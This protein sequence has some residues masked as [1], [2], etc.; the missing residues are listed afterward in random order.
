MN[1]P[2]IELRRLLLIELLSLRCYVLLPYLEIR[3]SIHQL[4][5]YTIVYQE[6]CPLAIVIVHVIY[7]NK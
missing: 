4:S 1:L 5:E 2:P 3:S 6:A 7:T